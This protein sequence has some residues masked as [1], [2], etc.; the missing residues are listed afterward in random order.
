MS[1][2]SIELALESGPISNTDLKLLGQG[3]DDGFKLR[4]LFT[5]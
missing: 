5:S 2:H 4:A 3:L 1:G